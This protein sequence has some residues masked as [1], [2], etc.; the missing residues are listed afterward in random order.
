MI[1]PSERSTTTG[2]PGIIDVFSV[3]QVVAQAGQP[4]LQSLSR[5]GVAAI[6]SVL[7]PG[8]DR[9]A[10]NRL[11]WSNAN[12]EPT[13]RG[14]T[15]NSGT[16]VQIPGTALWRGTVWP[17]RAAQHYRH[18]GLPDNVAVDMVATQEVTHALL[19]DRMPRPYNEIIGDTV[20]VVRNR[21]YV[22]LLIGQ[23][24]DSGRGASL[25]GYEATISIALQTLGRVAEK[26][27]LGSGP[28]EQRGRW[29]LESYLQTMRLTSSSQI[30]PQSLQ[31]YAQTLGIAPDAF[32][33]TIYSSFER[34]YREAARQVLP[35]GF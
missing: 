32:M 20:S 7:G 33:E 14:N 17:E 29:M 5:E 35:N 19:Q 21:A 26:H 16:I 8:V 12:D 24:A 34:G 23:A 11:V 30:T 9:L 13:L 1:S 31:R 22:M 15:R 27:G 10:P 18:L 2:H 25:P 3:A 28:P 4:R 6:R